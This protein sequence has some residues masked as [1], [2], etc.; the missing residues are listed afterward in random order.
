MATNTENPEIT[1]YGATRA[2]NYLLTHV[3]VK[4][5]EL[6][7]NETSERTRQSTIKHFDSSSPELFNPLTPT[8]YLMSTIY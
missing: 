5:L 7:I 6:K 3:T 1:A 2:A 8:T 4:Q